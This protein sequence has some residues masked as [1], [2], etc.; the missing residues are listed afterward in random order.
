VG[1]PEDI[2]LSAGT[3]FVPAGTGT[4]GVG[5][6]TDVLAAADPDPEPDPAG[7]DAD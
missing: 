1:I 5:I 4:T 6:V 7:P 3:P 2:K